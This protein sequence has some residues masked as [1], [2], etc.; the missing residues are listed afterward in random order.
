M[1]TYYAAVRLKLRKPNPTPVAIELKISA[2]RLLLML[3]DV[4]TNFR[5][6]RFFVFFYL[7]A[8]TDGQDPYCG[9]LEKPHKMS[10]Y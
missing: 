9:L 10:V 2:R 8:R 5:F 4:R 1:P 3:L 6:L 7:E